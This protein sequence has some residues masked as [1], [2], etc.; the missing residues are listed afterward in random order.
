MRVG[1]L[2]TGDIVKIK[3]THWVNQQL[4]RVIDKTK[5]YDQLHGD[6]M[7]H[8]T[9]FRKIKANGKESYMYT[10][11]DDIEPEILD[12]LGQR[13]AFFDKLREVSDE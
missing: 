5:E 12:F 4:A 13:S 1:D 2:H 8:A 6:F 3:L 11:A 9:T 7:H 10:L